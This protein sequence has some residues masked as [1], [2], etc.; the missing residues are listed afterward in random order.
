VIQ[1]ALTSALAACSEPRPS[2]ARQQPDAAGADGG[3]DASTPD[4]AAPALCDP[5]RTFGP[6]MT[7]GAPTPE[8]E[9]FAT[10]SGDEL[11]VAW[12]IALD[13]ATARV[14]YADRASSAEPFGSPQALAAADGYYALDRVAL[15]HDGRRLVVVRADRHGFGVAVRASRHEAFGAPEPLE[16]SNLNPYQREIE[17][18]D[19]FVGDPVLSSDGLAFVYSEYGADLTETLRLSVRQF[20]EDA[21]A[22]VEPLSAPELAPDGELRRRPTGFSRDQRTLFF[23][24]EISGSQR[25]AWRPSSLD[26]FDQFL[27]LGAY[28]GAQPNAGC[29]R[30]YFSQQGDLAVADASN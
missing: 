22:S 15:D 3:T 21:W 28:E 9:R 5:V 12:V 13:D 11:S 7:L 23:W 27:E 25:A 6:A 16:Y 2:P 14:F 18:R 20:P 10:I 8:V 24:D 4:G 17:P 19:S 26:A 1:L 29:R 30:L